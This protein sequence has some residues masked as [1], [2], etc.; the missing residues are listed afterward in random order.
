MEKSF[1]TFGGRNNDEKK[2]YYNDLEKETLSKLD[3]SIKKRSVHLDSIFAI[4]SLKGGYDQE[5]V[6]RKTLIDK[7]LLK[8][9]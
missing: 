6:S 5:K 7:G 3:T 1:F 8:K 4:A 2:V 9:N